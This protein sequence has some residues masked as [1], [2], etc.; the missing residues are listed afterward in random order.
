[1][2]LAS[3][4]VLRARQEEIELALD[5]A[6]GVDAWST[7]MGEFEQAACMRAMRACVYMLRSAIRATHKGAERVPRAVG[8]AVVAAEGGPDTERALDT[9]KP[10]LYVGPGW[11]RPRLRPA[12]AVRAGKLQGLDGRGQVRGRGD[13]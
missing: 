7:L 6:H 5:C 1:M 3:K 8:A 13:F 10:G 2:N 4:P 11:V 9:P 12:Q